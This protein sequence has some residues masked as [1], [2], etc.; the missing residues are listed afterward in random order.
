MIL[1]N[2]YEYS[3]SLKDD[4]QAALDDE[5]PVVELLHACED[6]E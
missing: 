1:F 2:L 4:F 5:L 6:F 3:G